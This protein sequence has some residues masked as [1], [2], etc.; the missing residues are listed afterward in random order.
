MPA[1]TLARPVRATVRNA[2]LWGVSFG[3]GSFALMSV[4]VLLGVAPAGV[5]LFDALGMALRVAFWGGLCGGVFSAALSL[6]YHGRRVSQIPVLPVAVGTAVGLG[7]FVPLTLQLFNLISGDGLVPWRLV[8][9]DGVLMG[10]LGGLVAGG[11]LKAA[12]LAER[13]TPS[14]TP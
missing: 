6:R 12:Q 8:L 11:M 4:S 5:G 7:L 2:A 3:A 1:L 13:V 9:D 10:T 14:E